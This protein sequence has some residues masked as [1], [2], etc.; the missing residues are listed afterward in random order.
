MLCE[1]KCEN[2]ALKLS[3]L[4]MDLYNS[5]LKNKSQ[6]EDQDYEFIRDIYYACLER[7]NK[8]KELIGHVGFFIYF[9][10]YLTYS[11]Y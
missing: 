9:N 3:S 6:F 7:A 8:K 10:F 5:N 2:Q 4:A 11:T 1:G